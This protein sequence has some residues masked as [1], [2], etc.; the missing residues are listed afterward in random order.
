MLSCDKWQLIK[1]GSTAL[2]VQELRG[3]IRGQQQAS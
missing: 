3:V 1:C 2:G